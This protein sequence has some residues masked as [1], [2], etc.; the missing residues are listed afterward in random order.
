MKNNKTA[1][2]STAWIYDLEFGK[3]HPLPDMPFYLEYAHRQCGKGGGKG[4][5]LD[6]GCGTGRVALILAEEG[7]YVTGLDISKPMLD[8]FR[9]KL[10]VKSENHPE[11]IKRVEIIQGDMT[12]FSLSRKYTLITAPFRT[13]QTLPD[14]DDLDGM[15]CCVREHLSDDG[16]FI[17]NAHNPAEDQLDE[18][19]CRAEEFIDEVTDE[20]TGITVAHYDCLERI[21]TVKQ[22]LYGYNAYS[23]TY[24]DN[25]IERLIEPLQL[26]YYFKSQL[27]EKVEHSGLKV[28]EEFSRYDKSTPG[29]PEVILICKKR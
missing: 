20:Q 9:K 16:I 26:K 27:I 1:C 8:I 11:L 13:I 6:L 17:V 24:S 10:S 23:I 12:A 29:E 22:I 14:E 28:L 25:R 21:D 2:I 19:W 3:K 5:I 7:F 18:K 4:D 15:F